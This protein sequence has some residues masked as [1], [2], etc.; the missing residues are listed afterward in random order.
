MKINFT[1]ETIRK[2]EDRKVNERNE[3]IHLLR[4]LL[5][6][7]PSKELAAQNSYEMKD[8]LACKDHVIERNDH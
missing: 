4:N 1:N 5:R 6:T 7:R 8:T 3:D 2:L